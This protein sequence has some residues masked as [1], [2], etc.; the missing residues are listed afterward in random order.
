M[1]ECWGERIYYFSLIVLYNSSLSF[2]SSM[3]ER[4]KNYVIEE[5]I[6]EMESRFSHLVRMKTVYPAVSVF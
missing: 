6:Q 1:G 2:S 4:F 3:D 5:M